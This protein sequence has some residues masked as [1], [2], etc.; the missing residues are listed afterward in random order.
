M[1]KYINEDHYYDYTHN[2]DPIVTPSSSMLH[3]SSEESHDSNVSSSL[4][5]YNENKEYKHRYAYSIG[6]PSSIAREEQSHYTITALHE[7]KIKE[8]NVLLLLDSDCEPGIGYYYNNIEVTNKENNNNT[9][10]E[11]E[12]VWSSSS[13]ST[14]STYSVTTCDKDSSK[15]QKMSQDDTI[16]EGF[17]AVIIPGDDVHE[18]WN[19]ETSSVSSD[20]SDVS[21]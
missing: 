21:I 20:Y 13:S 6:A 15:N 14:N 10:I 19:T 17:E 1:N 8:Q 2:N 9:V 5:P 7:N 11:F 3:S 16:D 4:Y 12:R 18:E